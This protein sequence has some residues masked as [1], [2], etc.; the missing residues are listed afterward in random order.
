[1]MSRGG[2]QRRPKIDPLAPV[3]QVASWRDRSQACG[4][5]SV[6]GAW[7]SAR[8]GPGL[9]VIAGRDTDWWSAQRLRQRLQAGERG[10]QVLG[11]APVLVHA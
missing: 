7:W 9:S 3:I 11:P 6:L 2:C 5:C 1:M 8:P 10:D 4:S